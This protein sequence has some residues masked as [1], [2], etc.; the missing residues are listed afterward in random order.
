MKSPQWK[1]PKADEEDLGITMGVPPPPPTARAS[2]DPSSNR[3]TQEQIPSWAAAFKNDLKMDLLAGVRDVVHTEL[4]CV[5]QEVSGLRGKVVDVENTAC[6]ALQIA[7]EAK[8][9]AADKTKV[10]TKDEVQS[11]V[12]DSMQSELK[13]MGG[14]VRNSTTAVFGGLGKESTL[15]EAEKW[16]RNEMTRSGIHPPVDVYMKGDEFAGLMFARFPTNEAMTAAIDT[17]RHKKMEFKGARVWC[18][19]DRPLTV[20]AQ[21]KFLLSFKK[22]LVGW[23]V[24][25]KPAISVDD[26]LMTVTVTGVEV[27][28]TAVKDNALVL[29]WMSKEWQEWTDLQTDDEFVKI[30]ADA[31]ATLEA[32]ADRQSKGKGKGP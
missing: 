20:R 29:N 1:R 26:E 6:K 27:L 14:G 5:K 3:E 8:S 15:D 7:E 10:I 4:Q 24:A 13:Q 18:N 23:D 22:L 11:L 16:I 31:N 17:C 28:K 12:K 32:S 2:G 9:I 30:V 25:K 21:L 19:V